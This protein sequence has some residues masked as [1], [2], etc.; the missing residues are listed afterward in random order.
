MGYERHLKVAVYLG[1]VSV[2]SAWVLWL[3]QA[4]CQG[5]GV[6]IGG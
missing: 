4:T 3:A 5:P 2:L 6:L 1:L